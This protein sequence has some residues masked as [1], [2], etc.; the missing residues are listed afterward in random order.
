MIYYMRNLFHR[1]LWLWLITKQS[2]G[3]TRE[4]ETP[5]TP[6]VIPEAPQFIQIG[7]DCLERSHAPFC[8]LSSN[9]PNSFNLPVPGMSNRMARLGGYLTTSWD[10]GHYITA[11]NDVEP[12]YHRR[13]IFLRPFEDHV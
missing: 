3:Q 2:W 9:R 13:R 1:R 10:F 6:S 7:R 12:E 8:N 4:V 5:L 11:D